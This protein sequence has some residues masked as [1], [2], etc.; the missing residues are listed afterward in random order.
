MGYYRFISKSNEVTQHYV[1]G[2]RDRQAKMALGYLA[3][4]KANLYISYGVT[5]FPAEGTI[6]TVSI[7]MTKLY[8]QFQRIVPDD[9]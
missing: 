4:I 3:L 7:S 2:R 6:Y 1:I 8:P 9:Q 5:R